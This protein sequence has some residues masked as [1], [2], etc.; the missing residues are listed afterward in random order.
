M[1]Y[2]AMMTDFYQLTMAYGYWQL[3]M[4]E[5]KAVFHLFS[6]R[7]PLLGDYIVACG[8]QNIVDLL[9]T[10][11]FSEADV[12]FLKKQK[13]P[14]FSEDFLHYLKNLTFDSDIDA[15]PEG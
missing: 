15:V 13:N 12:D 2:T 4:H 5:E 8:L 3:G 10:F 9:K 6:R 7:N 1:Q 14:L 11:R